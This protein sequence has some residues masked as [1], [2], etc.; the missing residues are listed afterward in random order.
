MEDNRKI[1]LINSHFL[2]LYCMVLADGIIDNQELETLYRIGREQYK[3]T[4]EEINK[5][6]IQNGSSFIVP[7]N[8]E[9]KIQFLYNLGTI[10]LADGVLEKSEKD[11]MRKYILRMGFLEENC[12][13]ISDFIFDCVKKGLSVEETVNL[14]KNI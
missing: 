8:I 4:Q 7:E 12:E 1:Q 10:A 11:L 5:A 3:L 2:A 6:I 14:A 13:E 9:S